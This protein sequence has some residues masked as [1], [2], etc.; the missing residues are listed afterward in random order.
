MKLRFQISISFK[1]LKP[2]SKYFLEKSG[3]QEQFALFFLQ[4]AIKS[5][6]PIKHSK[7]V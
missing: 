1:E 4:K 3:A 5:K 6:L 2:Y 7:E